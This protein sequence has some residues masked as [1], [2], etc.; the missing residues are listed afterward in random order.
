LGAKV[1]ID[2]G[3]KGAGRIVIHYSSLEQLD[4]ILTKMK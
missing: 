2:A 1:K 3:S 4:G